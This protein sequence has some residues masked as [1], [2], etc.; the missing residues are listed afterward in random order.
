MRAY[1]PFPG[2]EREYLPIYRDF[3]TGTAV[4]SPLASGILTGKYGNG[5]HVPEG[6]RLAAGQRPDLRHRTGGWER[7]LRTT[8]AL[9]PVAARLN[10]TMAQFAIAWVLQSP[11]VSTAIL[12]GTSVEQL[13]ENLGALR[14]ARRLDEATMRGIDEMLCGLGHVCRM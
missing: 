2:V 13:E 6:S 12:G 14:V 3:G 5:S 4:W 1:P 11:H 10:A 9:R 8:E 7:A